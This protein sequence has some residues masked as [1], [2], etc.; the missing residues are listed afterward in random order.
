MPTDAPGIDP[1]SNITFQHLYN[2]NAPSKSK[3]VRDPLDLNSTNS[4]LLLGLKL[5]PAIAARGPTQHSPPL[6]KDVADAVFNERG[7]AADA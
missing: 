4:S 6:R 1:P 7:I 2:Q 3:A 5:A